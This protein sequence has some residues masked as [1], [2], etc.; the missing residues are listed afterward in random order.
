MSGSHQEDRWQQFY[1]GLS[2]K[3]KLAADRDYPAAREQFF[4]DEQ[5]AEEGRERLREYQAGVTPF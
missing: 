1:W 3:K 2:E 5:R 4:K